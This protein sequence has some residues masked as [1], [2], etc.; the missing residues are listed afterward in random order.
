MSFLSLSRGDPAA[1]ELL[2]RSIRARYALR[3]LPIDS[4]RLEMARQ[5]KGPL[6]SP[7]RIQVINSSITGSHWRWD[8]SRKLFGLFGNKHSFAFDGGAYYDRS[9]GTVKQSSQPEVL[10]GLRRRLWAES[11]ALLTPLTAPDVVLKSIDQCTFQATPEAGSSLWVTI[12]LNPD[13]T[14]A[15]VEARCYH[16]AHHREMQFVIRP[17]DGLQTL[18]GFTVPKQVTF[19]WDDEPAETFTIVAAVANP[20]IP[21]TEFSIG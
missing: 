16:P 12:R 7:V 13:D 19:Q 15:S 20:K 9:G 4:V 14:V 11:A 3:P 21:L 8:Q 18:N 6:G 2:E 5:D 1:R 10:E 17:G